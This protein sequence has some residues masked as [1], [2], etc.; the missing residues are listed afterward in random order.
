VGGV[1]TYRQGQLVKLT[2]DGRT[3]TAEITIASSNGKSLF[4][5]FEAMINGHVG[6]MPLLQ[7]DDGVYRSII[8]GEPVTIEGIQ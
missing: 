7:G 4:V 3:V 6:G 8:T 1:V 2:A 5:R